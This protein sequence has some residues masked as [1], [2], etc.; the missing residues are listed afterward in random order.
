MT[1]PNIAT[2]A[3]KK[4]LPSLVGHFVQKCY[5]HQWSNSQQRNIVGQRTGN[6]DTILLY[7]NLFHTRM[8]FPLLPL[9]FYNCVYSKWQS[10]IKEQGVCVYVWGVTRLLLCCSTLFWPSSFSTS[11]KVNSMVP[12]T[13]LMIPD[14]IGL[15]G[16]ARPRESKMQGS[17][18]FS[19]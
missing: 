4:A 8:G 11:V 1:D 16:V 10:S 9:F 2:R 12:I 17:R 7:S 3:K 13:T 18:S 5:S 6:T 15:E 19:H 14:L